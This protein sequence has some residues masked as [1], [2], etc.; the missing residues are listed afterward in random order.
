MPGMRSTTKPAVAVCS[1]KDIEDPDRHGDRCL[2]AFRQARL[3]T[4]H[5][6]VQLA[7]GVSVS[8]LSGA[9]KTC[10]RFVLPI[11]SSRECYR[12][13]KSRAT[14]RLAKVFGRNARVN[15]SGS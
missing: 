8:R 11:K 13:R 5:D 1:V 7:S 10:S 14:D 6:F 15:F 12:I 3:L 4:C 2:L 9:S